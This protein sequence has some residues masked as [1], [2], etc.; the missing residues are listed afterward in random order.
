V[1]NIQKELGTLYHDF[2]AFTHISVES[3]QD[4][5][6]A[7]P[8]YYPYSMYYAYS[9]ERLLSTSEKLWKV[10]DLVTA[11]ILLMCSRFY[12]YKSTREY[13]TSMKIYYNDRQ[14]ATTDKFIKHFNL[15]AVINKMTTI[16][17]FL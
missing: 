4:K 15:A 16:P 9:K 10:I 5:D 3:L 2:S 17:K 13:L 14:N 8:K 1:S 11:I 12:G 7:N 6:K